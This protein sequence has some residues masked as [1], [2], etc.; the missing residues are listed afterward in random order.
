[1]LAEMIEVPVLPDLKVLVFVVPVLAQMVKQ[2]PYIRERADWLM[3]LVVMAM[4]LALAS[5]TL[6]RLAILDG[7]FLTVACMGVY[8]VARIPGKVRSGQ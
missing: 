1:M 2:V 4:S 5:L 6:G 3:P 8:G 7:L